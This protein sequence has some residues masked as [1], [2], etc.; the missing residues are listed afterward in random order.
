VVALGIT[1]VTA[2]MDLM[3]L[4]VPP[5]GSE[6]PEKP[7]EAGVVQRLDPEL[8]VAAGAVNNGI[9]AVLVA[10]GQAAAGARLVPCGFMVDGIGPKRLGALIS[11]G[12]IGFGV[13]SAG[14]PHATGAAGDGVAPAIRGDEKSREGVASS[15]DW[16][17]GF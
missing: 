16:H 1:G 3:V 13:L 15:I 5:F 14:L 4:S 10:A 12:S 8:N 2:P 17:G 6:K 11:P 9:P 7:P